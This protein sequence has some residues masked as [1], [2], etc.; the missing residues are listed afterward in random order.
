MRRW[1]AAVEDAPIVWRYGAEAETAE[2]DAR[3]ARGEV[4][5]RCLDCGFRGWG[6]PASLHTMHHAGHRLVK[7]EACQFCVSGIALPGLEICGACRAADRTCERCGQ[8]LE[9]GQH[10]TDCPHDSDYHEPRV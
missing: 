2:L 3:V 5:Y 10:A 6:R 8:N 1:R 7:E 9:T 4:V